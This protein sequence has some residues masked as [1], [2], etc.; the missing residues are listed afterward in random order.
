M[1]R[2]PL[3]RTRWRLQPGFT[4]IELLVVIAIIALLIALL[5]PAVQAVRESAR[6]SQC[7][8]NL[9]QLALASE[10]FL[11][12]QNK[13]PAG[14][15][16]KDESG[17]ARYQ[18][19]EHQYL[20]ALVHLLPHMEQS[21][22]YDK[23]DS[24]MNPHLGGPGFWATSGGQSWVMS[25]ALLPMFRCP[26]DGDDL[27]S[28]GVIVGLRG[29]RDGPDSGYTSSSYFDVNVYPVTAA[30][31]R[32]NYI[33]NAGG[34]GRIGNS[35]DTWR[36]PFLVRLQNGDSDFKDG[37]SNT[38]LFGEAIGGYGQPGDPDEG[39]FTFTH[40]WMGVG[41][42]PTA[43][44]IG[45]PASDGTGYD[46]KPGWYQY[47]SQHRGDIIQFAFGDGSVKS[48]SRDVAHWGVFMRLCGMRDGATVTV[49]F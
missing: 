30:I 39:Q 38:I 5:L 4:L 43:Y 42:M 22:V 32:T 2:F 19:S 28:K 13:L 12:A 3:P 29:V 20:G 25:Q 40:S 33:G 45:H 47:G 8:N 27:P 24:E 9:K 36:G 35:W 31:A 46:E 17:L 21:T 18:G 44:G 48:I 37:K 11:S 16:W 49:P 23:M 26:S 10:N 1:H 15:L 6:R 14:I 7:Q 34:F 41:I